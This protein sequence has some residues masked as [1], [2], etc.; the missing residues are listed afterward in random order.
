MGNNIVKSMEEYYSYV[1]TWKTI[2]N[3]TMISGLDLPRTFKH[4]R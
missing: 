2:R 4:Y 3:T 1:A